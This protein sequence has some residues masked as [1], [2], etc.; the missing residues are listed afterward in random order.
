MA[1]ENNKKKRELIGQNLKSIRK[2]KKISQ[3][4]LAE[5]AGISRLFYGAV[6]KGTKNVSVDTL[7]DICE[8][9]ECD[10]D[11]IITDKK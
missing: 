7:F 8:A 4:K 11:I 3:V 6:E 2:Q 5:S 10:I 1:K 9:L